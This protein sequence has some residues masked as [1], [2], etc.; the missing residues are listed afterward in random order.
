MGALRVN[1]T[2]VLPT[3]L[4]TSVQGNDAYTPTVMR[5]PTCIIPAHGR[6]L[7]W[8]RPDDRVEIGAF[9]RSQPE[10]ANTQGSVPKTFRCF[11]AEKRSLWAR[12]TR[13]WEKIDSASRI[14]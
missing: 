6:Y 13:L 2:D 12:K 14:G 7:T 5:A 8:E 3:N 9:G 4:L 10:V 11:T 1:A